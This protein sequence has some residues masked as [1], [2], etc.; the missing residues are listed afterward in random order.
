M[1]TRLFAG[2]LRLLL[3]A[4]LL[5]APARSVWAVTYSFTTKSD[6]DT[7]SLGFSPHAGYPTVTR[8]GVREISLIFPPEAGELSAPPDTLDFSQSRF[9]EGV[10]RI[11][12]GLAVILRSDAVGFVGWPAGEGGLKLQIYRDP[13]GAKWTPASPVP[14]APPPAAP[15]GGQPPVPRETSPGGKQNVDLPPLTQPPPDTRGPPAPPG[16]QGPG[17]PPLPAEME[18]AAPVDTP[19]PPPGTPR[20]PFFS[21]PH[22]L[23]A[24][25]ERAGP[26]EATVLRPDGAVETSAPTPFRAT[27]QDARQPVTDQQAAPTPAA[28]AGSAAPAQPPSSGVASGR[29]AELP[30]LPPGLESREG[31]IKARVTPPSPPIAAAP[32]S[33]VFSG[34]QAVRSQISRETPQ[35]AAPP[36]SPAEPST[37]PGTPPAADATRPAEDATGQ[38]ASA[39]PPETAPPGEKTPDAP[40]ESTEMSQVEFENDGM[41]MAAQS[42]RILG[43]NQEALGMLQTLKERTTLTPAQREETLYALAETLYDVYKTDPLPHFDAIQGAFQE[44]LNYNAKSSHIPGA[45]LVLGMLNLKAGNIPE[46]TAY[47]NIL[48]KRYPND[49]NI[50]LIHFYWGEHYFEKGDFQKAA[51]DYQELI[52]RYPESRFVREAS[53]GMAKSLVR[54][55]QYKEAWQIADYIEKRWPRYYTEFPPLLR[56]NGEIAYR[57][58][59]YAKS[60]DY[61]LTSYNIDPNAEGS[62]LILARLGDIATHMGRTREST[63][64]YEL[65]AA[66]FPDAEGGLISKMRLAERGVYDDPSISDM[67]SAFDKPAQGGPEAIYTQIVRDHPQSPLAPLAQLKL[68]MWQLYKDRYLQALESATT[69]AKLF[70]DNPLAPRAGEV[71]AAAF[72][73]MVEPMLR[74]Q[75]YAQIAELW[76]EHPLLEGHRSIISDKGQLAAALSFLRTGNPG[77]SLRL[78]L[79][80]VQPEQTEPGVNALLLA[81]HIYQ[82]GQAWR[83]ILSLVDRVRDWKFTLD[84]RQRLEYAA[85]Q[86]L[87][88]L[89]D[90]V[91]SRPLWARLAAD[92]SLSAPRRA[93]AMFYQAKEAKAKNDPE[94]TLVFAQEAMSLLRENNLDPDKV[95]DCLN[96]L[97]DAAKSLGQYPQ[98]LDYAEQYGKTLPENGPDFAANRFRMASIYRE[99]GE[100]DKWRSTLENMRDAMPDSRYGRMAASEL[101]ARA[102]E[103][104]A[105]ALTRSN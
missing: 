41:L 101:S 54:M 62:D 103:D 47:F 6:M 43:E 35:D 81:L 70:P 50:P 25:V 72:D 57:L 69:F 24:G 100:T 13:Q 30:P 94:K 73:R 42:R 97:V 49:E 66:R 55:G 74:N 48:R 58:G 56:I 39:A 85:A 22:S 68:A 67:F 28:P 12:N 53:M 104:R 5:A 23:R 91:R 60:K 95:T 76:R 75:Q 78:A 20:E 59:E 90:T 51:K 29:V 1:I 65:A 71:A 79:P 84:Q 14:P 88:H 45:L 37:S 4:A 18:A 98:A 46:A 31:E 33:P 7:L 80:F 36:E 63:E 38:A 86:A 17:L 40:A 15:A 105:R 19:T 89:G 82:E 96:M 77:E 87:E 26:A 27:P 21:V 10:R 2:S 93:I 44:A 61:Y 64:F 102:L 16:P 8:T 99:M 34:P 32:V 11:P 9:I 92:F 52:Q 3:L 83:E